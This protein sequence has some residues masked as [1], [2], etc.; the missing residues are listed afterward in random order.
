MSSPRKRL[1]TSTTAAAPALPYDLV[2]EIVARTDAATLIRCA[3]CCKPLR[4]E[5]LSPGFVRRVCREPAA[6]VPPRLFGFLTCHDDPGSAAIPRRW[7]PPPATFSLAHPATPAAVRLSEKHLA[8][9]FLPGGCGA[10]L[11]DSSYKHLT[12]RNGL[13][14]L[15]RRCTSVPRRSGICVYDPLTGG[16]HRRTFV[17]D[18]LRT[19]EEYSGC[20]LSMSFVLL[21]AS[22]D[23]AIGGAGG[24]LLKADFRGLMYRSSTIQVQT[25]SLDAAGRREWSPVTRATC[26]RS[27]RSRLR[28][29]CCSAVV[30]GSRI[31]WLM[32]FSGWWRDHLHVLTYDVATATAGSIEL[33]TDRMTECC[34]ADLWLSSTTDARLIIICRYRLKLSVWRLLPADASWA[35]H[36][37]IDTETALRPLAPEVPRSSPWSPYAW[38][39][40]ESSWERNDVLLFSV[41]MEDKL[42]GLFVIDIETRKMHRID[43]Q[44]KIEAFPFEV[45][46]ESRLAA[47]NTF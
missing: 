21:T 35:P 16:D 5:I 3:A 9:F 7:P 41:V 44:I 37:V 32:L 2:L 34:A 17:T 22:D 31:H 13:V 36:A 4:R 30:L 24:L 47:M 33:P 20:G 8:P 19:V 14:V 10:D 28:H 26:R 45:D 12:S 11:L 43:R 6:V 29:P 40:F 15:R 23:G 46:L 18:P 42:I 27:H 38:I 25:V 1:R 39:W